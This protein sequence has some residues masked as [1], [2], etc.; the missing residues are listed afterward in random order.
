MVGDY[1][2]RMRLQMAEYLDAVCGAILKDY[3]CVVLY[4][5]YLGAP[6][7]IS[8]SSSVIGF[9]TNEGDVSLG[10]IGNGSSGASGCINCESSTISSGNGVLTEYGFEVLAAGRD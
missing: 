6:H 8:T 5:R 7:T 10:S 9:Y 1:W 4:L 2:S 3:Y